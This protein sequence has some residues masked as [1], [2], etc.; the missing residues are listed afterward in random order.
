MLKYNREHNRK[1]DGRMAL[2]L[3]KGKAEPQCAYC[4]YADIP[5][6]GGV[7]VCRKVGGIMQ[8]YSKCKKYKYDPLKREPKVISFSGNFTKDDFSLD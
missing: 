1:G 8:L 3:F 4:E 5:E 7:A 2:K 6:G